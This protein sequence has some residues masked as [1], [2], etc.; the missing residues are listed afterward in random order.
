[1]NL[2]II[3][4]AVVA[5]VGIV[6]GIG[7]GLF[8]E[9][10]KVEETSTTLH[11]PLCTLNSSVLPDDAVGPRQDR[12]KKA[13]AHQMAAAIVSGEAAV[14][15]C[16]VG[17][18]GCAKA[19]G[20]IMG[21]AAEAADKKVAYVRCKGTCDAAKV[22]YNYQ[23]IKDCR[24][25]GS[26]PGAGDK[27]CSYGCMGYGSCV[28]ACDFD[29][30]HVVNGVAV[31]DKEKCKA[32][33]KCIA[34]CPQNL[35]TMVSYNQ[36]TFVQCRNKDR[37]PAVKKVCDNGCIGCTLCTKQCKF[38]AI[39]M[40]GNVPVIDETKCKNCGLCAAVCPA[41]VIEHPKAE[42]LRE[43]MAKKKAAEAAKKKAEAEAAKR[44]AEAAKNAE[45]PAEEAPKA[46][47]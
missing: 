14:N 29:A 36:K 7:L 30:I 20:D 39:H 18:E 35:I 47:A 15:G 26:V 28:S 37:G 4:A 31:V 25:A 2:V 23:G 40:E 8:G 27:A 32:C 17:G 3:S 22:Q 33:G 43:A 13:Y 6:V 46:E 42:Q 12:Q 11:F 38:D 41:K 5:A 10:F 24:M 9:K 16:P 19:I 44:A 1:M 21:V 45:V 34:A